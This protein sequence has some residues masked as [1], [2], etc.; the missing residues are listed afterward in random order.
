MAAVINVLVALSMA[1]LIVLC[2][3]LAVVFTQELR[4]KRSPGAADLLARVLFV[5]GIAYSI[6]A[7]GVCSYVLFIYVRLWF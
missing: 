1:V 3:Y 7:I 4:T 5:A 2:S 6:I